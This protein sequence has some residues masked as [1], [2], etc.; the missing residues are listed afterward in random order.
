MSRGSYL[1]FSEVVSYVVSLNTDN[2]FSK[3]ISLIGRTLTGTT[4]RGKSGPGSNGNEEI[5]HIPQISR[6]R[7]S[8]SDAVQYPTPNTPFL[9]TSGVGATALQ[10]IQSTHSKLYK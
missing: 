3:S 6:T 9:V 1:H 5:F 2:F 4:T 10:R 8:L 7:T